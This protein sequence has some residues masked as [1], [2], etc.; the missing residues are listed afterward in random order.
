MVFNGNVRDDVKR[1]L[2]KGVGIAVVNNPGTYLGIPFIW[3][4]TKVAAMAFFK[5]KV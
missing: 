4:K 2:A 3:E 5:E 1:K